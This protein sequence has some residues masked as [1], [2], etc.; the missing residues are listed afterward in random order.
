[1][2]L[3][4]VDI[5][6]EAGTIMHKKENVGQVELATISF[7]QSFQ[8][9]PIQLATT[10]SALVN[11][12]RRV[13]PHFGMEVLSAEGKKVKTFRYNAKSIL[14]LK[15]ITDNAGTSGECS[16]RRVRKECICRRIQDRGKDGNFPDTSE[17]CQQIY[18]IFC[19]ICTGR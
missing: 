19:R 3:T 1:M 12:G 14:C 11:G 15:N 9:T 6:G 16:G 8:I 17:K 2:D 13:T 5:P 4:G 18:I 7:G 10:V